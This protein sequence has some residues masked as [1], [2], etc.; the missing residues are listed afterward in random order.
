MPPTLLDPAAAA[1]R[2]I[3]ASAGYPVEVIQKQAVAF[4]CH[5]SI[6]VHEIYA[7]SGPPIGRRIS[8]DNH[9]ELLPYGEVLQEGGKD[10]LNLNVHWPP[11]S[12]DACAV[13]FR[14][15]EH[16]D[17][18]GTTTVYASPLLQ[19]GPNVLACMLGVVWGDG[20]RAFGNARTFPPWV[21]AASPYRFDGGGSCDVQFIP[22]SV[23]RSRTPK[24]RP[25]PVVE[26]LQ[27]AEQY[28]RLP[29]QTRAI[30]GLA[31]QRLNDGD[32]RAALE[33]RVID[34]CIALE[35]LFMEEDERTDQ[36]RLVSRR[37]SWYYADSVQERDRTRKALKQIHGARSRVVHGRT[38]DN[39]LSGEH[40][41]DG[42]VAVT[43]DVLRTCLKSM[44]ADGRPPSWGASDD[45]TSIWRTSRRL[46]TDIPS[47]KSDSMSW[48]VADQKQIDRALKAVW[49]SSVNRAE[50]QSTKK[51]GAVT[52]Q[53][54][55]RPHEVRQY[56]DQGRGV[57]I[58]HPALLYRAHPK[59]AK[60]PSD[61]L[62]ERARYYCK[63]D[64]DRH[65]QLWVSA[66][67]DKGLV[68]FQVA[69]HDTL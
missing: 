33:D 31:M 56:R 51:G 20:Y 67:C 12:V 3:L 28:M 5:G 29:R 43:E 58:V 52:I 11:A 15:F 16:K 26:L 4:S 44:I 55:L 54:P 23:G 46:D 18:D 37:A 42:T 39:L 17:E 41:D 60:A 14:T 30:V 49:Q 50:R 35:A 6:E 68:S 21:F 8:V 13:R 24:T 57:V 19:L 34:L 45:H 40:E 69:N 10:A 32:R 48:S 1:R 53:G 9:C 63:Q 25:L 66:A 65:L 36:R 61:E 64:V 59:W 38:V 7:L 2:L 47:V 62:D 27:L 22:L